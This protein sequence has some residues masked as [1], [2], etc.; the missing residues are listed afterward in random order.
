[1]TRSL[2]PPPNL[3]VT[4]VT[5]EIEER[6]AKLSERE[7]REF[8]L[9]RQINS[10]Q[11]TLDEL[12]SEQI[13]LLSAAPEVEEL[14][15]RELEILRLVALKLDN[16]EIATRLS[17]TVGTVKIHLHHVFEKLRVNGRHE[18]MQL[19]REKRY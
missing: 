1:M 11:K 15:P 16:Q 12:T 7:Q 13:A 10:A 6:R 4:A 3:L 19:L 2:R 5:V 9:R 14:S 17:I 18:L 8:D